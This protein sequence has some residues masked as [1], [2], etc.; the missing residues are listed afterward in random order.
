MPSPDQRIWHMSR[1]NVLIR[2]N[3]IVCIATS[4]ARCIRPGC[5]G[6]RG[7][8]ARARHPGRKLQLRQDTRPAFRLRLHELGLPQPSARA[9]EEAVIE[10]SRRLPARALHQQPPKRRGARRVSAW[11]AGRQRRRPRGR[12]ARSG[13][14]SRKSRKK[15]P[16]RSFN[17]RI[18]YGPDEPAKPTET[19]VNPTPRSRQT[20]RRPPK[21]EDAAK[22]PAEGEASAPPSSRQTKRQPPKTED[23]A[24]P[25]ADGE[26]MRRQVRGRRNASH[27]RPRTLRSRRLTATQTH[28]HE[29][30][31]RRDNRPS[32]TRRQSRR[33]TA[34]RRSPRGVANRRANCQRPKTMPARRAKAR[35]T[36]RRAAIGRAADE[37]RGSRASCRR[38]QCVHCGARAGAQRLKPPQSLSH[39]SPKRR[40]SRTKRR[41]QA[42]R[43]RA[44]RPPKHVL[45]RRPSRR[46]LQTR[47]LHRDSNRQRHRRPRRQRLPSLRHISRFSTRPFQAPAEL[48]PQGL[49]HPRSAFSRLPVRRISRLPR[50]LPLFRP[51]HHRYPGW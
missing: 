5:G 22:P 24:K 38:C 23:A 8:C 40:Q 41:R 7:G 15:I 11:A 35:F 26:R 31:S 49:L 13:R 36:V 17:C 19:N 30:G 50:L 39:L 32:P 6:L 33:A 12:R 9:G 44:D 20:T 43:G 46:S 28:R 10:R 21:T 27:L 29:R 34:M 25:P 51:A 4:C 37:E 48:L 2:R 18:G 3:G 14:R 47:A 16:H 45:P 1:R 42:P